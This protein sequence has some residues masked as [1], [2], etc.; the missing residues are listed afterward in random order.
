MAKT[1]ELQSMLE[2]LL[3][4]TNVYYQ[5]PSSEGMNYPAIVYSRNTIKNAFAN[6]KVY[7]Q[8]YTYQLIVIAQDPDCITV[9]DVSKLPTAVHNR[10]Y[11]AE[12]LHHDI[13]TITF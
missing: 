11:V 7:A 1:E 6:N 10:H 12:N 9:F 5:A 4:S 2:T 3:G 8:T 13:F